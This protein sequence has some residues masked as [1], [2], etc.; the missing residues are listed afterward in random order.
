MPTR[1]PPDPTTWSWPTRPTYRRTWG[2]ST[3]YRPPVVDLRT[4]ATPE[5]MAGRCW[6]PLCG[7]AADLLSEQGTLLLVQSEFA[8]PGRSLHML[9]RRR[10]YADIVMTQ[11]IPFGP[12]LAARA[13]WMEESGLLPV[14]RREEEI[15]VIR[16]EKP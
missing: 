16:A 1:S 7:A 2:H 15:V 12:V 11:I 3:K 13:R 6:I 4:P 14:C 9:R 5:E 10:L 8:D